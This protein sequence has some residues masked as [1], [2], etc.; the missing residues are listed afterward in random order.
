LGLGLGLE[1]GAAP[2]L[3]ARAVRWRRRIEAVERLAQRLV[4]GWGCRVGGAGLGVAG[5]GVQGWGCRVGGGRAGGAG[6]GV[7]GWGWQGWG[8]PG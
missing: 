1:G 6:L 2:Q 3:L 5:L 7:Q 4:Q 8:W